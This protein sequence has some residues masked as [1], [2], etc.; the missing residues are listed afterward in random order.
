MAISFDAGQDVFSKGNFR[1]ANLIDNIEIFLNDRFDDLLS[2]R[3]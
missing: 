2:L 3:I 1:F